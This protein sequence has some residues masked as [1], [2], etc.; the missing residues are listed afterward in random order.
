MKTSTIWHLSH[1]TRDLRSSND[2]RCAMLHLQRDK[3]TSPQTMED[4]VSFFNIA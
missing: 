2:I 1:V 3:G 4:C